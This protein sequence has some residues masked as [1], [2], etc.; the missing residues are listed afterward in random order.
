[1]NHYILSMHTGSTNIQ[2]RVYDKESI[3]FWLNKIG[4]VGSNW[5]VV[6]HWMPADV[7]METRDITHEIQ[8]L[9]KQ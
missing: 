7:V 3:I 6:S 1:M 2:I 8:E 5:S 9:L 4:Y